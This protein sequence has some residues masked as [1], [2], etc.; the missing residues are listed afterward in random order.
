MT[1]RSHMNGW[2]ANPNAKRKTRRERG[3]PKLRGFSRGTQGNKA[4]PRDKPPVYLYVMSRGGNI[5][6]VHRRIIL[7]YFRQAKR[8]EAGR[9]CW[10]SML[11]ETSNVTI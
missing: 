1:A 2:L 10:N 9:Y 8:I 5:L 4:M 3:L 7:D 11:K 6:T